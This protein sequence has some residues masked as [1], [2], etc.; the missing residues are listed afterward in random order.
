MPEFEV[1]QLDEIDSTNTFLVSQARQGAQD[2]LVAV[3]KYQTAGR[4]RLDRKWEAPPDASLLASILFRSQLTAEYLYLTSVAVALSARAAIAT[5]VDRAPSLKWPNDLLFEDK[6]VGGILAERADDGHQDAPA[7]VVG[8]GINLTWPGPPGAGGTSILDA[9]GINV[10][11]RVLLDEVLAQLVRRKPLLDSAEG[12]NDLN[13]EFK[14]SLATIGSQVRVE[15][16]QGELVGIAVG[17]D[18]H[19]HLLVD[20]AGSLH[21]VVVGDVIHLRTQP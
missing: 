2:G 21:E 3:A 11:P 20:V 12:R 15:R 5:L 4:G 16:F 6:K 7:V 18:D 9:S 14:A 1:C 13:D 17:V 10:R 8:I 19:G